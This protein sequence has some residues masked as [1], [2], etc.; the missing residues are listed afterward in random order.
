MKAAIVTGPAQT[1]VYGTFAD[2]VERPDHAVVTV[3]AAALSRLTRS[4]ADGSHYSADNDYPFVPGVDGT[5]RRADGQRVYFVLPDAPFGSMAERSLVA[6]AHCIPLPDALD[7]I[8]AAAIANPGMSSWAALVERARLQPGE[9]VLVNGATGASGR[10]AIEVARHLGAGR[11]IATGR[12]PAALQQLGADAT[13]LLTE[14][15]DSIEQAAIAHFAA[16]VDIVI[17]YLWGPSAERLLI[18][19]ARAGADARPIRFVQ[20]G[21]MSGAQVALPGAVLRASAIQLMGSGIGS[22]PFDRLIAAVADVFDAAAKGVLQIAT[23][24][25]P[26]SEIACAWTAGTDRRLVLTIRQ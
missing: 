14:D 23:E 25:A 21:E 5:G 1:P 9:T 7:D 8:T 2:P 4:R 20:V 17:D 15:G 13:I 26:L 22:V 11:V 12:D 16:G 24:T 6:N 10:L 18:A 3:S 19:G